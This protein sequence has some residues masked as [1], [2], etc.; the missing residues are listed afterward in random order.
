MSTDATF[1]FDFD[2]L[3]RLT[4]TGGVPGYEDRIRGIVREELTPAV[5]DLRSDGMGNVV[6]TIHGSERPDYAVVLAADEVGTDILVR[7]AGEN[8]ASSIDSV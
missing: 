2:L 8:E 6:G 3:G 1:D 5:D 4:E 7:S